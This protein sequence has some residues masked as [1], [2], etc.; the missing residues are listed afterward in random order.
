MDD[1]EKQLVEAL[2]REEPSA[3]F[4]ARVLAAAAEKKE[5]RWLWMPPRLRWAAALAT[6]VAVIGVA[7]YREA[8]ER[9]AGEA[10]KARLQLAL[11]ITSQKLKKIQDE[12]QHE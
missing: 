10:A 5:R 8:R 4:E 3:G 11:R 12:I 9:A 1:L 7:E 2:Q 6:V